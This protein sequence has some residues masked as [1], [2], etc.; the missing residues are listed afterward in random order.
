MNW[1]QSVSVED[2]SRAAEHKSSGRCQTNQSLLICATFSR[3]GGRPQS[4]GEFTVFITNILRATLKFDGFHTVPTF[5]KLKRTENVANLVV[6]SRRAA[7]WSCDGTMKCQLRM[8]SRAAAFTIRV[9]GGSMWAAL[10]PWTLGD[11]K[12]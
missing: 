9:T 4:A 12:V 5:G 8:T 3:R 7:M 6:C 10:G 11:S 2:D 1:G